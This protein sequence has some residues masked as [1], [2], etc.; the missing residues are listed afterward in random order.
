M[1]DLVGI[2]RE[3]SE[4]EQALVRIEELRQRAGRVRVEGNRHF[5]PGWH[6]AL[7]LYS[8]LS[9]SEA[10]TLSALARKESRGGHT[11]SDYPGTDAHLG[12]VN[13][14]ARRRGG[15]TV[16]DE[17]PL[18]EMPAELKDLFEDKGGH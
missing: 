6:L 16:L 4:L 17:E 11:R 13:L 9:V 18:P 14:V 12:S 2:I 1:Q 3:E 15:E 8:M 7:D 10:V 5:N